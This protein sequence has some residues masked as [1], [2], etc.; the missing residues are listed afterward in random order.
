MFFKT[1]SP[2]IKNY[3][4]GN[5]T[6]FMKNRKLGSFGDGIRFLMVGKSNTVSYRNYN[7]TLLDF[8]RKKLS[9]SIITY[10]VFCLF[11]VIRF[12][13]KK[14]VFFHHNVSG[15][16]SFLR[17]WILEPKNASKD[18]QRYGWFR[19]VNVMVFLGQK[20]HFFHFL[21]LIAYTVF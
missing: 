8:G 15:I 1:Y 18:S 12:W 5:K 2:K 9:F 13:P 17:Y 14:T 11:Y 7:F 3:K 19:R 16:L 4:S 20:G 21:N 6:V 10:P